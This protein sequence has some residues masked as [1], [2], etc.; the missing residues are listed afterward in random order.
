VT[1]VNRLPA[2][3]AHPVSFDWIDASMVEKT[4][5]RTLRLS[6]G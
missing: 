2:G 3:V 1:R 5:L 6:R 4:N